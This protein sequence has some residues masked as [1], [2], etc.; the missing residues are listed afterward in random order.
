MTDD[1][2]ADLG[3]ARGKKFL[4]DVEAGKYPALSAGC[5]PIEKYVDWY[6]ANGYT[7]CE[8]LNAFA[9]SAAAQCFRDLPADDAELI[10]TDTFM[11]IV[12]EL[13]RYGPHYGHEDCGGNL[14]IEEVEASVAKLRAA[15]D[16]YEAMAR[17]IL[18]WMAKRDAAE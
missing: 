8:T 13:L 15:V 4:D 1:N 7:H 14:T 5:G 17:H 6:L 9:Y 10:V 16:R 18:A 11:M 2:I 3:E 12:T